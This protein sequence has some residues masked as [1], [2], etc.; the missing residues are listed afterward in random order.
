[1]KR[2]YQMKC[3]VLFLIFVV[4]VQMIF[5][6][7]DFGMDSDRTIVVHD[8]SAQ[9]TKRGPVRAVVRRSQQVCRQQLDK[10]PHG[11]AVNQCCDNCY[12][13]CECCIIPC[14]KSSSSCVYKECLKPCCTEIVR[15]CANYPKTSITCLLYLLG[16]TV[17]SKPNTPPSSSTD[18]MR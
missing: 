4:S 11:K 18:S 3:N 14:V 16:A 13:C 15:T 1:M 2:R 9:K 6:S 8:D 5:P 12:E 17:M 7:D 10:Y